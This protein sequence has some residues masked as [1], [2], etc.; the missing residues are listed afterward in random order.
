MKLTHLASATVL[1]S[2]TIVTSAVSAHVVLETRQATIGKSYK[3]V[4]Q[5][6]HG[7]AGSPTIKLRVQIPEGV[8][9]AKP[10]PKPG[11]SIETVKG[12]YAESH[13]HHGMAMSEGVREVIW[14]GGKLPDDYYDEFVVNTFLTDALKPET[15]LYFP[16]VQECEQGTNAW[17]EIPEAGKAAPK[18]PAA[19]LK[20][21][22]K[23]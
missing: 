19:G 11:W 7:C 4:F 12:A 5:V 2:A 14:S 17:T 22:A 10:M 13:A 21:L 9:A 23:P 15:T 3:A 16:V 20:L 18:S 6:G 8:I 1:L